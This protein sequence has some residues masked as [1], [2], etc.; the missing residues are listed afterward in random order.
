MAELL[1]DL[2]QGDS[3]NYP[4]PCGEAEESLLSMFSVLRTAHTELCWLAGNE[5]HPNLAHN[6]RRE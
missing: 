4:V 1:G 6:F 3:W 5:R 2:Y